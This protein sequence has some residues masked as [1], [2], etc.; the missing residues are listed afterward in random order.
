MSRHSASRRLNVIA[1]LPAP[2]TLATAELAQMSKVERLKAQSD[3]LFQAGDRAFHAELDALIRGTADTLSD[4]AKEIAKHFGVYKQRARNESGAKT[5]DHIFMVR[6]KLP[7]GGEI[8]PAQWV[9]LDQAAERYADG[10]LRLTSR[11]GIQY[12]FVY[13]RHLR[14]LIRHLNA[15][16]R[17][18]GLALTTLGAC[19]D[20]NRNTVCSP[21]DDLDPALPLA[22]RELAHAIARELAPRSSTYCQIFLSD[23]AGR[24]LAPV[25][26]DEPLYG[27]HYLPRKFKVGIAHPHDNAVDLLTQDVGLL[28]VPAREGA[29]AEYDLYAGGGLGVT[30]NQPETR[31]YLALYLGRISGAQ[32]VA[33]VRALALIQKEHGER[34]DRRQARFKYTL[35]RVGAPAVKGLLREQFGIDLRDALPQPVPPV[36]Y[37][38]GWHREAGPGERWYLGLP[39]ENGRVAEG[40]RAA[41][42]VIVEETEAGVRVT[43]NQDLILCHI[44]PPRRVWV[45]AVLRSH[46]VAAPAR[47]SR[48]RRQAMA[49]PAKPTCGL[50]MSHAER[51]LPRYLSALEAAGLGGVDLVIRM[52][53]CPNACSRP[54]T[55]E[56]GIYGYGKNDFVIQVGGSRRGDRLGQVLYPRVRGEDMVETLV[57]LVRAVRDRRPEGMAAGDFLAYTPASELRRLA[58]ELQTPAPPREATA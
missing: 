12:H 18:R 35:R 45:E 55:A 8:A 37:H 48:L 42:R 51:L 2:V 14:D 43:P 6:V 33:A 23:D 21:I 50:A 16:Y 49:C 30:H 20:V 46:G 13:G 41:I 34:R 38:H 32:A 17:D 39:V 11:Q 10:T 58:A 44:R 15:G 31:Q 40:L 25:T 24:R 26:S 3:G 28:P 52:A 19:G 9:A 4:E 1:G 47:T 29:G 53:G 7:G 5:G 27:R 54:P 36:R 57:A 22:S 56:I